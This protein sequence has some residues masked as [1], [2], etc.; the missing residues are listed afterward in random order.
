MAA[1]LHGQRTYFLKVASTWQ[2]GKS[3]RDYSGKFDAADSINNGTFVRANPAHF[4]VFNYHQLAVIDPAP[5]A[6]SVKCD[7]PVH[8]D[9]SPLGPAE[10]KEA[11][12]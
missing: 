11:G 10:K 4:S 2:A 12:R 6:A 1:S 7:L 3:Y 8:A 5:D 9:G